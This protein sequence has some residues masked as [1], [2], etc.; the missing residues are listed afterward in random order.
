MHEYNDYHPAMSCAEIGDELGITRQAV[1]QTLKRAVKKVYNNVI[2]LEDSEGSPWIAFNIMSN[3]FGITDQKDV[4]M[5]MNMLPKKIQ[6]E[7]LK[8]A[9][10]KH[11][12]RG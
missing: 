3:F 9:R 1:S 5:F 4:N 6:G 2:D 10:D 12:I 7:I 8:D 11:I